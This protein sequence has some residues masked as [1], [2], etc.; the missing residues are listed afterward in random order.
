MTIQHPSDPS[1]AEMAKHLPVAI[2]KFLREADPQRKA[3]AHDL[4]SA[5]AAGA[6]VVDDDGTTYTGHDEIHR[7]R[8]AEASEYTYT[9]EI[10]HVEKF[11]DSQYVVTNHLE[12]DFPG[13]V[14]DIIY[15]FTLADGLIARLEIAP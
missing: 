6:T 1:A 7:W 4:L 5:F 15:R 8:E 10:S 13:G 2:V 14:V 11:D 9:V 3:N 12:G